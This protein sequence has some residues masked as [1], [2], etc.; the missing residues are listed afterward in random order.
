MPVRVSLM[1]FIKQVYF[2]NSFRW[3]GIL[4]TGLQLCFV[5]HGCRSWMEWWSHW[6]KGPE[7][8]SSVQMYQWELHTHIP[9]DWDILS[10]YMYISAFLSKTAC[11]VRVFRKAI[12]YLQTLLLYCEYELQIKKNPVCVKPHNGPYHVR[13]SPTERSNNNN[14]Q[15]EKHGSNSFSLYDLMFM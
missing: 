13:F 10:Q 15:R 2:F 14:N 1:Y 6:K 5:C 12:F 9:T 4:S 11:V 8:S 7:L 3:H